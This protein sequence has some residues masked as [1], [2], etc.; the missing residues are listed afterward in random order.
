MKLKELLEMDSKT[1]FNIRVVDIIRKCDIEVSLENGQGLGMDTNNYLECEIL[2]MEIQDV[3]LKAYIDS[4]DYIKLDE[5]T[6]NLIYSLRN[7][8]GL[9]N[10]SHVITSCNGHYYSGVVKD[11]VIHCQDNQ[12]IAYYDSRVAR[13]TDVSFTLEYGIGVESETGIP[14]LKINIK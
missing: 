6:I 3:E 10:L 11:C 4:G 8:K 13:K 1:S 12:S 14:L 9:E 5:Y 2:K 7:V